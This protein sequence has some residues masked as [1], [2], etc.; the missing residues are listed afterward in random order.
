M[1][2]VE[3]TKQEQK[4]F[5]SSKYSKQILNEQNPENNTK[6]ADISDWVN[7][8]GTSVVN[9]RLYNLASAQ[10]E[11][12]ENENASTNIDGQASVGYNNG[13]NVNQNNGG[14]GNGAQA[15]DNRGYSQGDRQRSETNTGAESKERRIRP[16]NEEDFVRRVTGASQKNPRKKR[17]LGKT[18]FAY[19]PSEA[20]GSEALKAVEYLK[21]AGIDAFYCEGS[22]E[23]N[24]K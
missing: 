12:T 5:D 14:I 8:I 2:G 13:T 4:L 15:F 18:L 9:S 11:T 19:T 10:A 24:K 1:Q 7:N 22:T 23:S 20:D 17:R 6:I 21:R 16:E 3:L